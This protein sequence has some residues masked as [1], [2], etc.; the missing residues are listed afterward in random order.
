[1]DGIVTY[2]LG[3]VLYEDLLREAERRA[4]LLRSP[5]F[6]RLPRLVQMFLAAFS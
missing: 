6:H 3:K 2:E 1:M 4:R 5:Q